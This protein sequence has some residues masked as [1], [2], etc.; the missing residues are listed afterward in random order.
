MRRL[1][2]LRKMNKQENGEARYY[3]RWGTHSKCMTSVLCSLM[4]HQSLVD[5]AVCCGTNTIHAHKCVLA[6]NSQYFREQLEKNLGTEQIIITGIDFS[7]VKTIVEYMYCGV[8]QV[9]QKNLKYMIA[10][11]KF[12]Q[13][14]GLQVLVGDQ[15]DLRCEADLIHI[16]H[17]VFLTKKPK[18]PNSYRPLSGSTSESFD[19]FK[20]SIGNDAYMQRK[21]KRKLVRTEAEKACAKEAAAS[22][23]TLQAL[24][25]EIASTPEVTSFLI[26]ESCTE[27]TVENF[28][29]NTEE[30]YIENL[31]QINN[32]PQLQVV[33]FDDLNNP[34]ANNQIINLEKTDTMD[35]V[36][37]F[38]IQEHSTKDKLKHILG[39]D[40]P[41]NV[42]IMFR[43]SE[44]DFVNVTDDVLQNISG[45]SLQYQ[46]VDENGQMGEIRALNVNEEVPNLPVD[47]VQQE[48]G[49]EFIPKSPYDKGSL[50]NLPNGT[51]TDKS[52]PDYVVSSDSS[53]GDSKTSSN[54]STSSECK[55]DET[56]SFIDALKNCDPQHSM[57]LYH[58]SIF[59]E[60]NDLLKDINDA[61]KI[62]TPKVDSTDN[63]IYVNDSDVDHIIDITSDVNEDSGGGGDNDYIG[64][65]KPR[66]SHTPKKTMS[67]SNSSQ[68]DK[69]IQK[70]FEEESLTIGDG[71]FN[72]KIDKPRRIMPTRK[73]K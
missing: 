29:P 1:T 2:N 67:S 52:D 4:E 10:A 73:K 28:I 26:E 49:N 21:I 70:N 39:T 54:G 60:C 15:P 69:M 46:I 55:L 64:T 16:P 44:G 65:K 31:D 33:N 43:T 19:S 5:V 18:Y 11:A 51:N 22:R 27:T 57:D 35:N 48:P 72:F 36:L 56:D 9:L 68:S 38:G 45:G 71:Q 7:V 58:G 41:G 8:I 12:F 24:Q 6:A 53:S 34:F 3:I 40:I 62:E 37:Q 61:K 23:L 50:S 20:N 42:E 25:L 14:R 66:L 13:L 32:V 47:N 30:A 59:D 63:V 17:P